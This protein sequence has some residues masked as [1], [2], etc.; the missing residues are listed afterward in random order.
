MAK[1]EFIEMDMVAPA[2]VNLGLD[3]G[4]DVV[5]GRHP[6]STVM[7]SVSLCDKMHVTADWDPPN[8]DVQIDMTFGDG[9][10]HENVPLEGNLVYKA[11]MA[12]C[13]YIGKPM[14]DRIHISL[15]KNIPAKSGLGGGSSD[16][17]AA[18][19]LMALLYRLDPN[20]E[21][22]VA[23]ARSLGSD[24]AF[25]LD[26]GCA[27]F[28]GFGDVMENRFETPELHFALARP[29]AGLGTPEVYK[30][31]DE[32]GN[33]AEAE[34]IDR[35][36]RELVRHLSNG[37]AAAADIAGA[38][39]NSLQ[40]AACSLNSGVSDII[41]AFD[42]MPGVLASSV[43]GSGSACYAICEDAQA[44]QDAVSAMRRKGV[45]SVACDSVSF[46]AGWDLS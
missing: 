26:G 37:G 5:D 35:M 45:W 21:E 34:R 39:G 41:S 1:P 2:K 42:S 17:A 13:N 36:Q 40:P 20:G 10:E 15:Q 33:G 46:G 25:F 29:Q 7:Q 28:G 22:A 38:V 9:V 32:M 43:S 18:I 3:V 12:F 31:F 16:C 44:A 30:A 14:G 23:V 24:V 8:A 11:I 19:K 6:L 4:R 27:V